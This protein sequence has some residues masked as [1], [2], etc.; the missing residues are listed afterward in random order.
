MQSALQFR[1]VPSASVRNPGYAEQ[2]MLRIKFTGRLYPRES[3]E[4][5]KT[6]RPFI[7]A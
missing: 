5:S 2:P 7:A 1:A 6:S 4:A 3:V